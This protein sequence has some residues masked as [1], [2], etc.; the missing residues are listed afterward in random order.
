M[1]AEQPKQFLDINGKPILCWTID[2]FREYNPQIRVIVA[3]PEPLIQYWVDLCTELGEDPGDIHVA[4]GEERFHS[5][6]NALKGCKSDEIIGVHDG[7]RPLV[8]VHTIRR[9]YTEARKSGSA[10]PVIAL[11]DSIRRITNDGSIAVKRSD[12]RIVQTPQVFRSDILFDAYQH[13]YREEFTDDASVVEHA[14][15]TV[16]LIEGNRENIKIT[17]QPDLVLASALLR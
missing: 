14:G 8:S 17:H 16:E 10:I 1:G 12:Y 3:L 6:K 7:V 2:V 4:G 9:A 13:D 5:I 11:N 15:Y